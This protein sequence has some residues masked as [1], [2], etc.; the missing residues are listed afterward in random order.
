LA[1]R[2]W[3]ITS[4]PVRAT[5]GAPVDQASSRSTRFL[6]ARWWISVTSFP[7]QTSGNGSSL[8]QIAGQRFPAIRFDGKL[9][10]ETFC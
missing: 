8:H 9:A 7:P 3:A 5:A 6:G 1:T 10:R 2:C 4:A